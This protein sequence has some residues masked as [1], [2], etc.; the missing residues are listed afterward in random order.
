MS[1]WKQLLIDLIVNLIINKI[2]PQEDKPK[3]E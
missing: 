2:K 1:W 3:D